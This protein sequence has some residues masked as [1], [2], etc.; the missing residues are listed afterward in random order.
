MSTLE[1]RKLGLTYEGAASPAL[2]DVDLKID[3]GE[4]VV[5]LGASGCGK[6]S[7]LN[8]IAG[9][10]PPTRGEVRLN[11]ERIEGPGADR[12]VVFRSTP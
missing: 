7:L 4:C 2:F 5:A 6:T 3:S 12:G 8:C 10:V 1:I 11:G 9:F